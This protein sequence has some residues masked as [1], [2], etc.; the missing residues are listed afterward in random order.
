MAAHTAI[1]TEEAGEKIVRLPSDVPL[2]AGLVSYIIGNQGEI[3]LTSPEQNDK[4]A[5][6]IAWL[7]HIASTPRDPDFMKERPMNRPP[8]ENKLFPDD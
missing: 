6:W 2:K 3:V 8:V 7:D 5:A 1:V 4:Q